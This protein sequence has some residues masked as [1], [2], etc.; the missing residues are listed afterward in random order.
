M[1]VENVLK[2][3]YKYKKLLILCGFAF[4]IFIGVKF[5]SVEAK[6]FVYN[7]NSCV[8][9][10]DW[11]QHNNKAAC[12]WVD[13]G[14]VSVWAS[15]NT[16]VGVWIAGSYT[17]NGESWV[18]YSGSSGSKNRVWGRTTAQRQCL[19]GFRLESFKGNNGKTYTAG[20]DYKIDGTAYKD[21]YTTT[22]AP[23][24]SITGDQTVDNGTRASFTTS[25]SNYR[26]VSGL[27][28]RWWIKENSLYGG[29]WWEWTSKQ[30][31]SVGSVCYGSSSVTT[32][33]P[34][35]YYYRDGTIISCCVWYFNSNGNGVYTES[36]RRYINIKPWKPT[37][38]QIQDYY[39]WN[40]KNAVFS[41]V[42]GSVPDKC[43][44]T[45][46]WR[47]GNNPWSNIGNLSNG[48]F[49]ALGCTVSGAN[50]KTLT[51]SGLSS[52]TVGVNKYRVAYTAYNIGPGGTYSDPAYDLGNAAIQVYP[53]P[54][55]S[56]S[57]S[58]VTG[59]SAKV[60]VNPSS[61]TGIANYD[62][63][64]YAVSRG[65]STA[66][67]SGKQSSNAFTVYTSSHGNT[68]GNYYS[69]AYVYTSSGV[70]AAL[71]NANK[72]YK[73]GIAM[74]LDS[75]YPKTGYAYIKEGN[76]YPGYFTYTTSSGSSTGSS[77]TVRFYTKISTAGSP[78]SYIYKWYKTGSS[79]VLKTDS[80][81]SSTTSYLELS[82]GSITKANNGNQYYCVVS[83]AAGSVQSASAKLDVQYLP[84][85]NSSYPQDTSVAS[86]G[87]AAFSVSVSTAGNPT[88]YKYQWLV[89][90]N[91]VHS[92]FPS[93]ATSTGTY[94]CP[95][96]GQSASDYTYTCS[97]CSQ[98]YVLCS[99]C[100]KHFT[101]GRVRI[102]L[103]SDKN[104][105]RAVSGSNYTGATTSRLSI[106]NLLAKNFNGKKYMCAVSL[107]S[108]DYRFA[109]T[110]YRT[111]RVATLTVKATRPVLTGPS[112]QAVK[113]GKTATFSVTVST[114]GVPA[115]D[116]YEWQYSSNGGSTWNTLGSTLGSST[117]T[118]TTTSSAYTIN[119]SNCTKNITGY[120]FRVVVKQSSEN[121]T[122]TSSAGTLTVYYPPTL[123]GPS[124][125]AVGAGDTAS[126]TVNITNKGNYPYYNITWYRN[127]SAVSTKTGQSAASQ[128]YSVTA[129]SGM[130]GH[131]VYCVITPYVTSSTEA[132]LITVTSNQAT[133]TVYYAPVLNSA[134]PK[135][136]AVNEG[137]T[138]TFAVSIS[139]AGNPA[140]YTY[141]WYYAQPGASWTKWSG[142]T[143]A[144]ATTS[145]MPASW[146]KSKF[147]CTV[148]QSA[149]KTSGTYTNSVTSREA[150]LTV[151][152]APTLN[153]S[154]P[155]DVTVNVGV[156]ASF[157]VSISTAG[158]PASYSY[159]WYKNTSNSNS[160]GSAISGAT[161]SSYTI[162]AS[163]VTKSLNG[164]YYY[165]IVRTNKVGSLADFSRTSRAAKLTVQ[166]VPVL[167]SAYPKD[168][169]AISGNA[170][171]F[172]VNISTAGNPASYTYQWYKNSKNA[173]SGGSAISSANSATYTIAGSSVTKD[174]NNTYY[175]AQV[176][177]AAGSVYS[178][179]AKLTVYYKPIL[180]SAY[181]QDVTVSAGGTA[182]FA[183]SISTAGNPA[184]YTYQWYINSKNA[185]SGGSAISSAT[186]STYNRTTASSD[187]GT[188]IYCTVT[189][190][191]GTVTS[192]AAKLTV[193]YKPQLNASYPQD[194]TVV[195]GKTA[196]FE[197][198]ISAAGYPASYTCQW[199][200]NGSTI[201][202]ATST[203]Y[204]TAATTKG[205]NGYKYYCTVS[206]AGGTV[207]SRTATLTVQYPAVLDGNYPKNASVVSGKKA[208]FEVKISTAG[209][210]ASYSYQ[211]YQNGSAVNGATS[212]SY[213]TPAT[214]KVMNGYTYYCTVANAGGTV[215]SRT[216]TLTV[217]Y[218]AILN[219]TYPQD[220]S[221]V[222]GN[223][224]MFEVKISTA[225]NPASY[226]YQWY[227]K[228][229]ASA[230]ASAIS[231]S[232]SAKYTTGATTEAM[233]GSYYYCTVTNA[234][235]SVTSR[236][237]KLTVYIPPVLD[238]NK[239]NDVTVVA[240]QSA[241]FNV[242]IAKDGVPATYT[243][244][245]YSKISASDSWVAI[246]G[247]T[248]KSYTINQ[249]SVLQNGSYYYCK[250]TNAGGITSSRA[251]QLTVL[252]TP[253][254]NASK[255]SDVAINESQNASFEIG[256]S[257]A[258][259]PATYTYQWYKN[260][261]ND[262][263]SGSAV[264]GATSASYSMANVRRDSH[265]TYYYCI[266]TN[267]AGSKTSRAA[268]LT[269]YWKPTLDSSNPADVTKNVGDKA[270][271]NVKIT[272]AG[273]PDSYQYQWYKTSS[274][275]A[276][277]NAISGETS[278][279]YVTPTLEKTDNA[280]Y[281]YCTVTNRAGSV[282]SRK[283]LLTVNCTPVLDDSM[284]K[285]VTV[286]ENASASFTVAI[287]S[288]GNPA[289]YTYQWYKNTT[290]ANSNGT[291]IS[292]ATDATYKI[293]SA[294]KNQNN[295]YYY[296]NVTNIVGTVTSRAAKLTVQYVPA[297]NTDYPKDV[298][299]KS[300]ES[301]TFET[302]ISTAGNPAEYSYQWYYKKA[303]DK[304]WTTWVSQTNASA[305]TAQ[306]GNA[307]NSAKFKC[308]VTNIAGTVTSREATLT[309]YYKPVLDSTYPKDLTV[310]VTKEASFEVKIS[311]AGNPNSYQYQWYKDD[312]AVTGATNA[313]Y[314][315]NASTKTLDGS[316]YHCVV[317]NSAGSVTS[318]D[319][320]L[321]VLYP[322]E[323]D[324]NTPEDVT[325]IAGNDAT[326]KVTL[327]IEGT[328]T[329]TY[330]W[331]KNTTNANSS[332]T[333]IA[334][335]TKATYTIPGEQVTE[336]I[337][338]TYYYCVVT[339]NG[340]SATSRA[341]KLNVQYKVK[342]NTDYPKDVSVGE[343]EN[344]KFDIS[345]SQ[346]GNP[347]E[348]SY[349]WYEKTIAE[350]GGKA[351]AGA[352]QSSYTKENVDWSMNGYRYY[353][354]V[355]N[356]AGDVKSREAQL[357]VYYTPVLNADY[358]Q[359][360]AT[361]Q[362]KQISFNVSISTAGNPADYWYQWY[363]SKNDSNTNG[364]KIDGATKATY[365]FTAKKAQNNTYYYCVVGYTK[366]GFNGVA[367]KSYSDQVTS[368]AAK[369][370]VYYR[371]ELDASYPQ[372][373][374][375]IDGETATFTVKISSPGNPASYTYQWYKKA[376]A[377]AMAGKIDK[378]TASS[379][380]V[381]TNA[382]L[383]Q[384]QYYCVVTNREG[385]SISRTA[386]LTVK[387]KPILD[388]AYPKDL[389]V[390]DGNDATFKVN[391]ATAGNPAKYNYQWYYND[392]IMSGST[393]A[394]LTIPGKDVKKGM[395]QY[396][397][398]CVVSNGAGSVTSRKA[399]LT[400][401][402]VPI[403]HDDYP[404]D[405]TLRLGYD[406]TYEV[407]ISEH[408]NPAEY[409]YQ[410]YKAE[411]AT[412]KGTAISGA[413]SS[414]YTKKSVTKDD[415]QT[416]YYCVVTNKR[417]SVESRHAL[418]DVKYVPV[419]DSTKPQD[420]TV[421]EGKKA[422]F[423]VAISVK[424]NPDKYEYQW[425]RRT[426]GS[427]DWIEIS[428]ATA[429]E[430]TYQVSRED[431]ESYYYCKVSN[432]VGSV[433]SKE[434]KLTVH[435]LP[436]L[437][438]SY[439]KDAIATE[440][441][442]GKDSATFETSISISGNPAEYSYQWYEAKA[443]EQTGAIIK[444]ATNSSYTIEKLTKERDQYTYYCIV[445]N[446]AG[447]V[448]SRHATL[449]VY[450]LPELDPN[451][452][453]DFNVSIDPEKEAPSVTIE[454]SVMTPGN[455]NEY[456]YEWFYRENEEESWKSTGVTTQNLDIN[457]ITKYIHGY[458]F[459]CRVTNAAGS[460]DS[461]IATATAYYV[462]SL[463]EITIQHV[464]EGESAIFE[465]AVTV[466]GNPEHYLY[467]WLYQT[468]EEVT[469]DVW[470]EVTDVQS[471]S[472]VLYLPG[473]DRTMHK[474]RYRCRVTSLAGDTYTNEA[475]LY[476]YWPMSAQLNAQM[477]GHIGYPF[478][479]D[480]KI[481]EEG[482]PKEYQYQWQISKDGGANF[483][484]ISGMTT[485]TLNIDM[486][487]KEMNGYQYRCVVTNQAGT[488][489]TNPSTFV[490]HATPVLK[491]LE[492]ITVK[493]GENATF[494]VQI[495][496]HGSPEKYTYQWYRNGEAISGATSDSYTVTNAKASDDGSKYSC[497]VSNDSGSVTTNEATLTVY[498][499]PELDKLVNEPLIEHESHAFSVS[500]KKDGNP[501]E[502]TYQWYKNGKAISGATGTE[503]VIEDPTRDMIGDTYYYT[504]T[505]KAGT[506]KSNE[507]E[508][509]MY[510]LPEI[511]DP[512]DAKA[513][514][515]GTAT[516]KTAIV[517]DGNPAEYTYQWFIKQNAYSS[518]EKIEG[519]TSDTYTFTATND[520]AE[521][522]FYVAVTNKAGTVNSKTAKVSVDYKPVIT[523]SGDVYL[524]E[525]D[526]PVGGT[527]V[528]MNVDIV[529]H[530]NPSSYRYQWYERDG[531]DGT[532]TAVKDATYSKL[533]LKGV[534]RSYNLKEYRC[535]VST[536][537]GSV[538]SVPARIVVYHTPT[539]EGAYNTAAKEGDSAEFTVRIKSEGYPQTYS[540]QWYRDG[541]ILSGETNE[542][543]E[544]DYVTEDMNGSNFY[545]VVSNR[546]GEVTSKV[547]T[548]T[549]YTVPKVG[550][551]NDVTVK[552]GNDA[553]FQLSLDGDDGTYSYQWYY[554]VNARSPWRVIDGATAKNYKAA[555]VSKYMDG[556]QYQ[557]RITN[558]GGTSESA[559][560]TLTVKYLPVLSVDTEITAV[561]GGDAVFMAEIT[562]AG[563]A[564]SYT[565]KLQQNVN[566]NWN[567][568]TVDEVEYGTDNV[569]AAAPGS[570]A[571]ASSQTSSHSYRGTLRKVSSK[572]NGN[573]YRIA[574]TND[575]GTV[576][577]SDIKLVVYDGL[578][579]TG[580]S[581][582]TEGDSLTLDV[583]DCKNVQF[584]TSGVKNKLT[585]DA[586]H[587]KL[588]LE[589]FDGNTG[590]IVITAERAT[591]HETI[592]KTITVTE[593]S[594]ASISAEYVGKPV[595]KGSDYSVSDVRIYVT[596]NNGTTKTI[597]GDDPEVS[598][599]STKVTS[600]VTDNYFVAT[601]RGKS[602]GFTVPGAKPTLAVLRIDVQPDKKVYGIGEVFDTKGMVVT[603][604]YNNGE[605][606]TVTDY[607]IKGSPITSG[608]TFVTVEYTENDVTVSAQVPISVD[609]NVTIKYP[610]NNGWI[611]FK[612][613]YKIEKLY[614]RSTNTENTS[615]ETDGWVDVTENINER[616][617]VDIKAGYGFELKVYTNY[618]T[619]RA[620]NIESVLSSNIWEHE[621]K[622]D[623]TGEI[624]YT[625]STVYPLVTPIKNP[626]ILYLTATNKATGAKVN[627]DSDATD[628]TFV[629]LEK[630]NS[631]L[632][633]EENGGDED[634][635]D[636]TLEKRW[637]NSSKVFELRER[638]V[639][640]GNPE[641]KV[642]TK[643]NAF[644]SNGENTYIVTITS[645]IWYGYDWE[646][647]TDAYGKFVKGYTS[648]H[649][650]STGGSSNGSLQACMSFELNILANNDIHTHILQ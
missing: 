11:G 511:K 142:A 472:T 378:A 21:L 513:D 302:K 609:E 539:L 478:E 366:Q 85:L 221:V 143:S 371:P 42:L 201:S 598:V 457:N 234:G 456:T 180:N 239:P 264:S 274:A 313:I 295:T 153:A 17:G 144:S 109:Y 279:S 616:K 182:S 258:G 561:N 124:N 284:P 493:Q 332:G 642:Y 15:S 328:S 44:Q 536:D 548:M 505:N 149:S 396:K 499:L 26:K 504:V 518:W 87:T 343:T 148:S 64:T 162:A 458:Q 57:I 473:V 605:E 348:Y 635:A 34:Y 385:S 597:T 249:T 189:N 108:N 177:N 637:D 163:S 498:Y 145:A 326:F 364:T 595:P 116:S 633:K 399:T 269:V 14:S 514:K 58:N 558:A 612:E 316:R 474:N 261:A 322:A 413:K 65:S 266:I 403:L 477:D 475:Y 508:L 571:S 334:G 130:N 450:Y 596:Y 50:S 632:T 430:Y 192:R 329:P 492:D 83:N 310:Q 202:S 203:S 59:T 447:S 86:G 360:V 2:L 115:P 481:T 198:C 215:T 583:N 193:N 341:A 62:L 489:V 355:T 95:W 151:Y 606:A 358:P 500:I 461:R 63:S 471:D 24:V 150:T 309:V 300:G 426:S 546:A 522:I 297:L 462:P 257:T 574:V 196:T 454:S 625:Y 139:I 319:A 306:L 544:I 464:Y 248:A 271:F 439:P 449:T 317:T 414:S 179:A 445:T 327:F 186:A 330:Q 354:I 270:S 4:F 373:V 71:T 422:V 416:Y 438:S 48:Y 579:I 102:V 621:N 643:E 90:D 255:P 519:A 290:N 379:Y 228:A 404:M 260:T 247:A 582:V 359:D 405:V 433:R 199:Y 526:I 553:T 448:E 244:Q 27:N 161:G 521:A 523:S 200:Q 610:G 321:T 91:S 106:S 386:T 285:D 335:A 587:N 638:E 72:T 542:T 532:W 110:G 164:T 8:A 66:V 607:V 267:K 629:T 6:A 362:N 236:S 292:G 620:S 29:N 602:A 482:N 527:T 205:M 459:F 324:P 613:V 136:T 61:T 211:W 465:T 51:L 427:N 175:Y 99:K 146:N 634:L 325:V 415:D 567:D 54:S 275:T 569:S 562:E 294:A 557:C 647:G 207:T 206:N 152:Y 250:V 641:R 333:A 363:T 585:V 586:E 466:P 374:T 432:E 117:I 251:A 168:V 530:G 93:S 401:D 318:R 441:V 409:S 460:V 283:A 395:N 418:L 187:N 338:N 512:E 349:Q 5:N 19:Y 480:V 80:S 342:L 52:S 114:A 160:D 608:Q 78:A 119:V 516:F 410:W 463:K 599:D 388:T 397:Y 35:I 506:V 417:G 40:S 76:T 70:E 649:Y 615:P 69:Q 365:T 496:Q 235:G 127:G 97:D 84:V 74:A 434:A 230:S 352:V 423:D 79:T 424:G 55:G 517:K 428:G 525:K 455:P 383:N 43:T 389:E 555:K 357:T 356:V 387:Y 353:C 520:Y 528:E 173:N 368:R 281:Y 549:V 272:T 411:N 576:Y 53:I 435:W 111:S 476:V 282:A 227:S 18:D 253:V 232:N 547:G 311:T 288:P 336:G 564:D 594:V 593:K 159:Q 122:T 392:A 407:H 16:K 169:N 120:K 537:A 195:V 22:E 452:P 137:S 92:S 132:D 563:N 469:Q 626:D 584:T 391:I 484:E 440:L 219:S 238:S 286:K 531:Y 370:T 304:D 172:S 568:V 367:T 252:Y 485:K 381:K 10:L 229:N 483:E 181:P 554:R 614:F 307:W 242:V 347:A 377:S 81:T 204:T 147:K 436:T 212:A 406:A 346:N 611:S 12:V 339:N 165:C 337:N 488:V 640:E 217:Q 425:Y 566:G 185:N 631:L 646:A 376:S 524:Y 419:L 259:N 298:T 351:I 156:S 209:N 46:Q 303:S 123:S 372:D 231:N 287:S 421:I 393:D 140:N 650:G 624:E 545:C 451:L 344:A 113:S 56:L 254:L 39:T 443:G 408:G 578:A 538:Y 570:R 243:Y 246:N 580:R 648:K 131:Q 174:I 618:Y 560:G 623:T 273:N 112:N 398:H 154:Y 101:S 617:K 551:V 486:V 25:V 103:G 467:Q 3:Y 73:I 312:I 487:T 315:F 20:S 644:N 226:S 223:T 501:D 320:V 224:A 41:T 622:N 314:K 420:T 479:E 194:K 82:A 107:Y 191:A 540:Y 216:A 529:T 32:G 167:N 105:Y 619:N 639:Y 603:A 590:Q 444:G 429:S 572:M 213:T 60:T 170:A 268:K 276:G 382:A 515:D 190:T 77:S 210:P 134:Y 31:G 291:A 38:S 510:Y 299:I 533:T 171:S 556:Y 138:A 400:V 277:G 197:V 380:S 135:D 630:T 233:N 402:Y 141:Q 88:S 497:T 535:E 96:C 350:G 47:Y 222:I 289:S 369:L 293:S 503:Y 502:Y 453:A 550:T 158:N 155:K 308:E 575:T 33:D 208:T 178:R 581:T 591:T 67:R 129:S 361:D 98:T 301:A 541:K 166:Y 28:Y 588:L 241:T 345:V 126:F 13:T 446:A 305:T 263:T 565:Y 118:K 601:Y 628:K 509:S 559:T 490:A 384:S 323:I 36:T 390:F 375:K 468:E 49:S 470:H 507:V 68:V 245:W 23:S 494:K 100:G 296:C 128:T 133:M 412:A 89:K 7:N 220:T 214:T 600:S 592:T 183:V 589:T 265:N 604:V 280:K 45:I 37:T 30:T 394:T 491:D 75:N 278:A 1:K 225:G 256:I 94:T 495:K 636:M 125:I 552:A 104:I 442:D 184:S 577:S 573:K 645:P 627:F 237:A 188:Y 431:H 262:N 331:Y 176:S 534:D 121:L 340:G 9:Y 157:A 437:D 543:Y 240:G 218:P